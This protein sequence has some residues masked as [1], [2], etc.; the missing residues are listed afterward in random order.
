MRVYCVMI[1]T[2]CDV[3]EIYDNNMFT[4]ADNDNN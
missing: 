4:Q 3:F 2:V 1:N